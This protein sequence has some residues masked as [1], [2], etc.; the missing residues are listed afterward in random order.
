MKSSNPVLLRSSLLRLPALFAA[1]AFFLGAVSPASALITVDGETKESPWNAG[2]GP[3]FGASTTGGM[4]V[5]DGS[6][7]S[8]T[9]TG[10]L[11]YG[12]AGNGTVTV[13]GQGSAW[14]HAG[15]IYIG[16]DGRGTLTLQNGGTT[17]TAESYLGMNA[18]GTG[19]ANVTTGSVWT[20]TSALYVGNSGTG[21]L[22]V[23]SGGKV[24]S[25][26]GAYLGR[27]AGSTGTV[28][29]SGSGS[30]WVNSGNLIVGRE[31]KGTLTVTDGGQ[32]TNA[33]G[34]IGSNS[35]G[36]S[37]LVRGAG[38]VWNNTTSLSMG[39]GN[40]LEIRDGGLVK[41]D[42]GASLGAG[43]ASFLLLDGGYLAWA[44]DNVASLQTLISGGKVR[45]L[46]S[47]GNW[48]SDTDLSHYSITY[49]PVNGDSASLT[50][51]QYADLDGYTILSQVAIPEPATSAMLGGVVV[52]SLL[53]LRGKLRRRVG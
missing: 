34:Y 26:V 37:V 52:A 41:V 47:L 19:T 5:T 48:V 3:S 22:S 24:Q 7:V 17:S 11:G 42:G 49:V 53:C 23:L 29:V 10:Y 9:G 43:N 38:S 32:V 12:S 33:I 14:S 16:R 44:G 18:N 13:D 4:S 39:A 31:G 25:S 35:S 8:S 27:N 28:T 15:N 21:T 20:V 50:G 40:T 2:N 1:G 51:G 6:T 36:S 45:L 46:D 30:S